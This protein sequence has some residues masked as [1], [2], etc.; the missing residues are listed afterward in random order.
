MGLG[1]M[2]KTLKNNRI[3]GHALKKKKNIY[4][5]I[6]GNSG[7][8][9]IWAYRKFHVKQENMLELPQKHAYV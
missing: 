3:S 1:E 7:I 2:A 9:A 5:V 6:W 8:G 4:I